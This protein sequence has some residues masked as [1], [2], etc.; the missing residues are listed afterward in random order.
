M[1]LDENTWTRWQDWALSVESDLTR[2]AT[3]CAMFRRFNELCREHQQWI[4]GNGG[5]LFY[6][7]VHR[8]WAHSASMAVRRHLKS[9]GQAV[10]LVRL[11]EQIGK[12]GYQLTFDFYLQ[13]FPVDPDYVDWQSPTFGNLSTDG[14]AVSERIVRADLDTLTSIAAN[15]EA[16]ADTAVAHLDS[17]GLQGRVAFT[18]LIDAIG[19]YN[20][21]ACKYICFTSGRG[22][23]TLEATIQEPWDNVFSVPLIRPGGGSSPI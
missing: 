13:R 7:A 8:W 20:E 2:T 9:D 17:P 1:K 21:I 6:E 3:E 5:H 10:S 16:F 11:I 4:S 19:A 15:I 23:E 22:F 12:C 14:V 18:D